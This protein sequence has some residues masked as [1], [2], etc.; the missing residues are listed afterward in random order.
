MTSATDHQDWASFVLGVMDE[1]RIYKKALTADDVKALY[2]LE[3][4]GK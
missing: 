4:L 1:L 2:N 3:N